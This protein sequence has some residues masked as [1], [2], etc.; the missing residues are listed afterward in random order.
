MLEAVVL[1]RRI[2]LDRSVK[3]LIARRHGRE[4]IFLGDFGRIIGPNLRIHSC[5]LQ[6]YKM[7][8][9]FEPII[10]LTLGFAPISILSRVGA[11]L[12]SVPDPSLISRID[13]HISIHPQL[14][15]VFKT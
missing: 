12:N 6:Q 9:S 11:S 5:F 7:H 2:D 3:S 13:P 4:V 14:I 10:D 15:P 8:V 1:P